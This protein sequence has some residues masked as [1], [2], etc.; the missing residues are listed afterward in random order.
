MS[1]IVIVLGVVLLVAF[2]WT[3][4]AAQQAQPVVIALGRA[5]GPIEIGMPMDRAR[6]IMDQFGTVEV[7]DTPT[8]HGFCNPDEG[9]GVC[10]FDKW[11]RLGLDTPGTVVFVLTDDIRFA[12]EAGSLK[13]GQP[14]LDFLRAYGLYSAGQGTELLWE[15]RGLSVD[16]G[17]A[18]AGMVVRYIGVFAPRAPTAMVVP[19][20]RL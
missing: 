2:P 1:R 19:D 3:P 8:T 6:T 4:A 18:D 9:V 16:V 5:I 7:V 20:R 10:V 14:L 12:T 13:V 15:T 17:A 11:N